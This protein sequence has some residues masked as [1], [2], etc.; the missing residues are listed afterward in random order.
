MSPNFVKNKDNVSLK[1]YLKIEK[2]LNSCKESVKK[3]ACQKYNNACL[4][5]LIFFDFYVI[6]IK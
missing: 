5:G 3:E 2:F 4:E 1:T 6:L